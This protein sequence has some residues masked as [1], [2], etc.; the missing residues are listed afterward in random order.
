M[1]PKVELG[2]F[3]ALKEMADGSF[4]TVIMQI[5]VWPGTPLWSP[6]PVQRDVTGP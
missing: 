2:G 5:T 4:I 1:H 6:L 3:L